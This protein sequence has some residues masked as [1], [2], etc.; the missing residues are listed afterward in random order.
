MKNYAWF[1]ENSGE[2]THPV[3]EL[4]PNAWGLYD[5]HGNVWEC[6]HDWFD[7][8]YYAECVDNCSDPQ[9]PQSGLY[10]VMR[11]GSWYVIAKAC[12]CAYRGYDSP[13]NTYDNLGFRLVLAPVLR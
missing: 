1:A 4:Q 11:G 10:C 2:K 6:C 13:V 9:G 8:D 5:M 3:G 12:R 7:K